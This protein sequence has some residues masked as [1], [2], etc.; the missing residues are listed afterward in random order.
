MRKNVAGQIVAGQVNSR[1]DGSP[2]TSAVTVYVTIDGGTQSAGGGTATHEGNGHWSYAPTQAETNGN[3]IAFTFTHAS[4]VNQTVNV[5]TVSFDPH[6]T[7]R[8]GLTALP[9]AAAAGAGG[10]PVVGTGANNFKSDAS[11]NVT[12]ANTSI[13][14]VT[15]LTNLPAITAGWLTAAGIAAGALNGKGDWLL[16][17]GYTAPDNATIAAIQADTNDIQTRLPAALVGGRM[18]ASVGAMAADALTAAALAADAVAE[19]QAGLA[20]PGDSMALTPAA[21]DAIL[22]EVVDGGYTVRQLMRGFAAALMAK[23]SGA[24]INLPVFRD[25]GDTKDRI[26]AVTDAAGNRTAV[27]LDLT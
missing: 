8:L 1:T 7:V 22:D 3:H 17:S 4:G 26:S 24:D 18:D 2:L 5:Y 19:I 16:A 15:N 10:L 13:A 12:F 11:A 14:T 27:T 23:L 6:D 9:N 21:I 25:V 20:A